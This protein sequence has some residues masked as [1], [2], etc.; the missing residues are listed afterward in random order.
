ML[1]VEVSS[2]SKISSFD[3]S[4]PCVFTFIL[5]PDSHSSLNIH[6]SPATLLLPIINSYKTMSS[7]K[8]LLDGESVNNIRI[9]DTDHNLVTTQDMTFANYLTY[10]SSGEAA[11]RDMYWAYARDLRPSQLDEFFF[12]VEDV[13][14]LSPSPPLTGW[15]GSEHTEQL[16]YDDEDNLHL[17]LHGQKSWHIFPPNTALQYPSFMSLLR[18]SDQT[19]SQLVQPDPCT[20]PLDAA[21]VQ[22]SQLSPIMVTLSPGDLLYLPA[23][24]SHQVQSLPGSK[25]SHVLSVNKFYPTSL[26]TCARRGSGM[27]IAKCRAWDLKMKMEGWK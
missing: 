10:I 11:E 3:R 6:E 1:K 20:S 14:G 27:A 5:T 16:H 2:F 9:Y 24:W 22:Q 13:L 19:G 4:K 26:F 7:M 25:T 12:R 8:D 15:V 18:S 21:A 23:A 17:M